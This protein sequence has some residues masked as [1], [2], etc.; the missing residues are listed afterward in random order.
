[1]RC[2]GALAVTLH[3]FFL[4]GASGVVRDISPRWRVTD[5]DIL[6]YHVMRMGF[7]MAMVE[8]TY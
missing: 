5:P 8:E 2:L 1:M 7:T 4:P 6:R 3:S